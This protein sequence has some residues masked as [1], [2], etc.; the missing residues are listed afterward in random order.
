MRSTGGEWLAQR[1]T[2]AP[3]CEHVVDEAASLTELLLRTAPD[4]VV[5]TTSQ[6]PLALAGETLW[7]V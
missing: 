5:L 4:L 6:E 7:A 3:A 2:S 1:A